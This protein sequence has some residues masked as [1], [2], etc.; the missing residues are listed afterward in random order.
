MIP[1]VKRHHLLLVSLLLANA[2]ATE[3]LPLFIDRLVGPVGA[4]LISVTAVLL[5]GECA[6]AL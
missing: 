1:L 3:T 6:L 5:F 4:I 2:A